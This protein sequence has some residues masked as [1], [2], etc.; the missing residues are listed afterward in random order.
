ML[1]VADVK[2][3]RLHP[4]HRSGERFKVS[5]KPRTTAPALGMTI[6]TNRNTASTRLPFWSYSI[7]LI[8]LANIH[9]KTHAPVEGAVRMEPDTGDAVGA[10]D[11]SP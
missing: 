3:L 5:G 10:F 2:S 7:I 9:H 4:T 8:S 1:Y 11:S 6:V